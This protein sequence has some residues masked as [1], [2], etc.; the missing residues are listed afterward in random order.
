MNSPRS[1]RI[2]LDTSITIVIVTVVLCSTALLF[3][4]FMWPT[5]YEYKI[6]DDTKLRFGM[7]KAEIVEIFGEPDDYYNLPA[8][9]FARYW[10]ESTSHRFVY[11]YAPF[12]AHDQQRGHVTKYRLSVC[13]MIEVDVQDKLY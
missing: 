9:E 2:R 7:T 1:A 10:G 4:F 6:Y 12:G 3:G 13:F 5:P 8:N 11:Q